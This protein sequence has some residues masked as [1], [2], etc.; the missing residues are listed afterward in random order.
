MQK[1]CEI[2]SNPQVTAEKRTWLK[3]T[4]RFLAWW[5]SFFALLGPRSVCPICGQAGCPGGTA[6][7]GV[8][9]GLFAALISIPRWIRNLFGRRRSQKESS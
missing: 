4:L 6:S 8:F 3:P 5:F 9:G 7:A 2:A 1:V